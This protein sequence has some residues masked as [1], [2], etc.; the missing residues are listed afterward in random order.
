MRILLLTLTLLASKLFALDN[1]T[2]SVTMRIDTI[3]TLELSG[4]SPSL[5]INTV[6]GGTPEQDI[7]EGV[8][9][10]C[11]SNETT[12]KRIIGSIDL[13]MPSGTYLKVQFAAPLS[14]GASQG[15]VTLPT[16][17]ST[18]N[19]VTSIPAQTNESGIAVTYYLDADSEGIPYT[20]T[21]RIATYTLVDN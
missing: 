8:T 4:P 2:N 14:G 7:F 12:L 10:G 13:D 3:N 15:I 17:P 20:S 1:D 16:T 18:A 19:L 6:A 11:L 9:Y 21:S 5:S